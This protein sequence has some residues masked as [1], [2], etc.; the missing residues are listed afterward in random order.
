MS[1]SGEGPE[2]PALEAE[3]EAMSIPANED[4]AVWTTRDGTAIRISEMGDGHLRNAIRMF[5]RNCE[6]YRFQDAMW[7][8]SYA[9]HAPDGAADAIDMAVDN[10]AQMDDEEYLAIRFPNYETMCA[11][12]ERRGLKP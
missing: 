1:I 7:M 3:I 10:L 9:E 2:N 8:S 5:R 4:V 6:A 11:E 12:S